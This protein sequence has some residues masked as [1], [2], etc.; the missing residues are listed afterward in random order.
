MSDEPDDKIALDTLDGVYNESQK[1][2]T[3]LAQLSGFSDM[4]EILA[5]FAEKM[6]QNLMTSCES[7][8]EEHS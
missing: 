7:T 6:I 2:Y 3:I 5:V 8:L 4:K 1:S